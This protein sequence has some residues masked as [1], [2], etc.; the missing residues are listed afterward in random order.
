MPIHVE[1][2]RFWL[3][4]EQRYSGLALEDAVQQQTEFELDQIREAC[5]GFSK[6]VLKDTGKVQGEHFRDRLQP[7]LSGYAQGRITELAARLAMNHGGLRDVLNGGR[8]SS[9]AVWL[10]SVVHLC[11]LDDGFPEKLVE[12]IEQLGDAGED[13]LVLWRKSFLNISAIVPAG[14]EHAVIHICPDLLATALLFVVIDRYLCK[15]LFWCRRSN[16]DLETVLDHEEFIRFADRLA[17]AAGEFLGCGSEADETLNGLWDGK[18]LSPAGRRELVEQ[19][20][21]IWNLYQVA[22]QLAHVELGD[23]LIT[24]EA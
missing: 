3:D 1:R 11:R 13:T 12:A 19:L 6:L 9:L 7:L 18:S 15:W 21:T 2:Q 23:R 16:L 22:A 17:T 20:V 5:P 24:P 14:R 10:A 8:G 4:A